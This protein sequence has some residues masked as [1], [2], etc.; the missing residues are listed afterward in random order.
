MKNKKRLMT[1]GLSLL[2]LGSLSACGTSAKS[3]SKQAEAITVGT[4]G[5]PKPFTYVGSNKKIQG[6]DIDTVRAID[7][8][9]PQYKFSFTKTEFPSI[10]GGLTAGR[11]QVGANNFAYNPSRAKRYYYSKPIFHDKYVLVVPKKDHQIKQFDD[12]AGK[13]TVSAPAVNFTT[14]IENFNQHAKVKSKI[15]Y[16]SEDASKQIQDVQSGK[17]DY[18]LIDKP[19]YDNYQKT[20]HFD[21]VKA[22]SLDLSDTKKISK[23]TPYSF[24]LVSKTQGGK[25]LL[26]QINDAIV[27]IQ[28]NGT[29]QKISEKY[30]GEN[31]IPK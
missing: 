9:L 19:L 8:Q 4:S 29:A 16:S 1:V 25:K 27:K 18:V 15:T 10:L 31:Y 5:A 28:K 20:Y 11:F 14:A 22:V 3:K 7:Q 13:T 17:V 12:I 6:F 30:F 21:N 2:I 23:T 24:L 26:D